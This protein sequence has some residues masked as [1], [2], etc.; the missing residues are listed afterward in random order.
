MPEEAEQKRSESASPRSRLVL[1]H[2]A[3][4]CALFPLIAGATL[5]VIYANTYASWVPTAEFILLSYTTSFMIIGGACLSLS[6]SPKRRPAPGPEAEV[7]ARQFWWRVVL[8][9]LNVPGAIASGYAMNTL[10]NQTVVRVINETG[11]VIDD[12]TIIAI[13]SVTGQSQ[14]QSSVPAGGSIHAGFTLDEEGVVRV[15]LQQGTQRAEV[16]VI[17][18]THPISLKQRVRVTSGLKCRIEAWE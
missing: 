2:V 17:T 14:I 6:N 18:N 4:C 12:C 11:A 8:L 13:D 7:F 15:T 16:D 5:V 1:L 10:Q 3:M 9:L